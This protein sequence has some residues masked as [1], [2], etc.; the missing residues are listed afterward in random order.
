MFDILLAQDH[1]RLYNFIM[2]RVSEEEIIIPC[3][4]TLRQDMFQLDPSKILIL[5]SLAWSQRTCVWNSQ[6][7]IHL[8]TISKLANRLL[9]RRIDYLWS[10]NNLIGQL[11]N[12][13]TRNWCKLP[14]LADPCWPNLIDQIEC[15]P[16]IIQSHKTQ[17]LRLI[18]L[19]S[20]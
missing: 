3:K 13:D 16:V 18:F 20:I 10:F 5:R 1:Q 17:A 11:P 9:S 6:I 15:K 8:T 7:R 4:P 12:G 2:L 19:I 14:T